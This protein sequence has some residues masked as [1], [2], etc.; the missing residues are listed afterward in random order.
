MEQ[1]VAAHATRL[2]EKL[3]RERLST[4]FNRTGEHDRGMPQRSVSTTVTLP[5]A[6][7]DTLVPSGPASRADEPSHLRETDDDR[8][9]RQVQVGMVDHR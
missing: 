8:L 7:R 9:R 5:E 3:R 4:V 6:T 1:A 2:G